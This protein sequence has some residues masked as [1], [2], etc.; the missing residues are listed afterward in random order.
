MS[1][2]GLDGLLV[3]EFLRVYRTN[4]GGAKQVRKDVTL[5]QNLVAIAYRDFIKTANVDYYPRLII[6]LDYENQVAV[7]S[8]LGRLFY[9]ILI[10]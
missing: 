7:E 9:T 2:I 8:R 3:K 5:R 6:V 4:V 10:V 1:I